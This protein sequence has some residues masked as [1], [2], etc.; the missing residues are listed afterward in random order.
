[1]SVHDLYEIHK[2]GY[3][4]FIDADKKTFYIEHTEKKIRGILGIK[5]ES[6]SSKTT[7]TLF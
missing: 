6:R 3:F 7:L 4:V 2:K 1:M 5:K